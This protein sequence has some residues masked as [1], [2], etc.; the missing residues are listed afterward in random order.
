MASSGKHC[1]RFNYS[2][3]PRAQNSSFLGQPASRQCRILTFFFFFLVKA[4]K[5]GIKKLKKKKKPELM[6]IWQA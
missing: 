1:L 6:Q 3:H 2:E 4:L 5:E